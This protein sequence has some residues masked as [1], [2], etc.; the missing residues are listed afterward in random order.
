MDFM[1]HVFW[2]KYL[3]FYEQKEDYPRLYTIMSRTNMLGFTSSKHLSHQND[4]VAF[5]NT[6]M[7]VLFIDILAS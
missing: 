4:L 1:P 3:E 6:N 7:Y 5:V 2:D